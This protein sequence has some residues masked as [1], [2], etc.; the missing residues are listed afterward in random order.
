VDGNNT[1]WHSIG[2]LLEFYGAIARKLQ[3][4]GVI[5]GPC[6]WPLFITNKLVKFVVNFRENILKIALT[7]V[8]QPKMHQ[9]AF[10]GRAPSG[11]AGGAYSLAGL[12]GTYF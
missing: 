7:N 8:F 9:I 10:G 12:R 1:S 4:T 11:P 6:A 2:P 3:D 5:R